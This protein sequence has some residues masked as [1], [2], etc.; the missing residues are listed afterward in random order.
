MKEIRVEAK[1]SIRWDGDGVLY[2]GI[3]KQLKHERGSIFVTVEYNDG[4]KET[5]LDMSTVD[6]EIQAPE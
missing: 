1:V 5:N 2:P 3:I 6:F 4:T